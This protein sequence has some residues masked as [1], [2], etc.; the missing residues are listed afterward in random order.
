MSDVSLE[1][2]SPRKVLRAVLEASPVQTAPIKLEAA[3]FNGV[4]DV[5][6][7][8]N[9]VWQ[10]SWTGTYRTHSTRV[11]VRPTASVA[12]PVGADRLTVEARYEG[13][14]HRAS[15]P[16]RVKGTNPTREQIAS[17]IGQDEVLKALCWAESTWRQFD[18]HGAPLKNKGSSSRGIA[19]IMEYYWT[20]SDKIRHNDYAKIAWQW[21]YCVEAA[22]EI[23]VHYT[24]FVRMKKPTATGTE[25]LGWLFATYHD[26]PKAVLSE[27]TPT[28][29]AY[30]KRIL[31]YMAT[32][33]W[34]ED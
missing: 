25:Q 23:L 31:E 17:A 9:F 32:K 1:I 28:G 13:R 21:D 7:E 15:V 6:H 12:L 30:A 26:G 3:L 24:R 11:A 34:E 20:S 16:A 2:V 33:P 18:R 5:T 10:L 27:T 29:V 14:R 4:T 19:Q 8:A 22:R